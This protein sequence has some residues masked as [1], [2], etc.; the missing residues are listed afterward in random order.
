MRRRRD[1]GIGLH[2]V[3]NSIGSTPAH[4]NLPP[5]G[6]VSIEPD[7]DFVLSG[8]QTQPLKDPVEVVDHTRMR[9]V[10]IDLSFLTEFIRH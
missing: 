8:T 1:A 5:E 7:L 6:P 4:K 3:A 2:P 9:P 10:Q